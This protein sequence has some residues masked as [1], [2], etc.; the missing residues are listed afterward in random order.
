M[1]F[2]SKLKTIGAAM[3][4]F[5]LTGTGL[6]MMALRPRDATENTP[7]TPAAADKPLS[8]A[9][10]VDLYGDPL[11]AGAV[12]RLGTLRRR[13]AGAMLAISADGKS[14][15]TLTDRKSVRIFDADTGELRHKRELP[16]DSLS[17]PVLSSDG[18]LLARFPSDREC[19][20]IR[21]VMTG[22][23]IRD[24]TIEGA[25]FIWPSAFSADGK[26]V[27]AVG[28]PRARDQKV[29]LFRAWD[30]DSGKEIFR[31]E[32]RSDATSSFL[33]FSPDG[34]RL[35]SAFSSIYEGLHCWDISTGRQLWHVKD[36]GGS[37]VFTPD[38]KILP[39]P[40]G[41]Q[42]ID[43][44]TGKPEKIDKMPPNPQGTLTLTP[45]GHTLLISTFQGVIVWDMVRGKEIRTLIGQGWDVAVTPDS[46]A[47]ITN[48]GALQ[49]W[50]LATGKAAWPDTFELGHIGEVVSVKFSDDGKRLLSAS[51]D[52]TVR[53]WDTTT[54]RSLRIW[55]RPESKRSVRNLR[56]DASRINTL[57]ISADGRRMVS[58]GSDER[59][60]LWALDSIKEVRTIPLPPAEK[61]EAGWRFYQV[62]FSPDG[63]RIIGIFGPSGGIT[64]QGQAPPKLTNKLA[65]WD[66]ER[67]SLMEMHPMTKVRYSGVFSPDSYTLLT[68]NALLDVLSAKK[69]ADLPGLGGLGGTGAFSQDGAL[70]VGQAQEKRRQSGTDVYG[71]D[72]LRIW[73]A[74]T[75]KIVARLKT[76]SWVA[77]AAFH[78]DNR[79]IV[80][81][82]LDGIR[83]RGARSGEEIAHFPMPE[84]IRAGT[85]RGS[86]AGCLAFTRDGKR[87]ATGMPDST[88][89]LWDV[90]LPPSLAKSLTVKE[91][92]SL[93]NNLAD[94]DAAKAWSAVWCMADAPQETVTFLRVRIKPSPTA[95]VDA[96]RRLLGDL[97]SD[98]FEVREA[99]AK[100]LK[101]LGPQAEPALRAALEDKPS[102]E[103][104]RRI[105]PLLVAL[106]E[107]PRPL[108]R[109]ELRQ[110]RALIVL[111]RIGS[112]EARRLLDEVAKGPPSS[113][114]TRQARAALMCLAE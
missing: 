26:R 57:D 32:V 4:L 97:D 37:F 106:T 6:G 74:A 112:P 68:G 98:S 94:D 9:K 82:D 99:A 89:L 100:R 92:E 50:D 36:F 91:I 7:P 25:R 1:M 2:V 39:G 95:A 22:R 44:A 29:N 55:D 13:A 113:R 24:L 87:M 58:A 80:T 31:T 47:A 62:R 71:P 18:R 103:Q 12:M 77:Q 49:R 111:E 109:E 105:E 83:L 54:G 114:S 76:K 67:G 33:A 65:V 96:T 46:K 63:R 38:G 43:L 101:E 93:W 90:K 10:R 104:R 23:K 110:L 14:I 79:Y 107:S 69:I 78:P 108:A 35:L 8:A 60:H 88:I 72:G 28:Y 3:I 70:I 11:P 19:L 75:G 56:F 42:A 64:R 5:A 15:V 81:N 73:E 53:M 61:G 41:Q 52:D 27:A 40:R 20:E 48:N 86:Y 59:I 34:K 30:L 66:A 16:G 85:T 21:D 102:L 45:D 17:I 84:S 51:V